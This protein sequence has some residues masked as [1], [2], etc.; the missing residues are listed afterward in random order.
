M[1]N[2]AN[3]A[4]FVIGPKGINALAKYL[5]R[6]VVEMLLHIKHVL[7]KSGQI[8]RLENMVNALVAQRL[9]DLFLCLKV[10]LLLI[11]IDPGKPD[12]HGTEV[13]IERR[14]LICMCACNHNPSRSEQE[15][16]HNVAPDEIRM[17]TKESSSNYGP[18]L[19]YSKS[20]TEL[21]TYYYWE[22][23]TQTGN[24][25][26][27]DPCGKNGL[28]HVRNVVNPHGNIFIR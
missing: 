14:C 23:S 2:Q 18:H 10:D 13:F 20:T 8:Y 17:L 1:D 9:I 27:H 25:P 7:T 15:S 4:L 21:K 16:I 22:S 5:G 19:Y 11:V 26:T 24:W 28:F 6:V 3:Q 12:H